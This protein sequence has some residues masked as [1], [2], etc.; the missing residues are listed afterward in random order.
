MHVIIYGRG[1]DIAIQKV[2]DT[3]TILEN[4]ETKA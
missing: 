3:D 2:K 4:H 1:L